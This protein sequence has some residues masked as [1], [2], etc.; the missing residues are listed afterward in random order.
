MFTG[1]LYIT[2]CAGMVM[3]GFPLKVSRW[4]DAAWIAASLSRSAMWAP[5]IVTAAVPYA[6]LR[7]TRAFDPPMLVCT[8]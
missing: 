1:S 7:T 6:L 5:P 8:I 4:P 2:A 3:V